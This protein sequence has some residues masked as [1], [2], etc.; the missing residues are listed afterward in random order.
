MPSSRPAATAASS[1]TGAASPGPWPSATRG[2]PA[3]VVAVLP[4]VDVS[5]S[6]SGDYERFFEHDGVR[7]HHLIDPRSGRSP[8]S[9][10][11]VTILADDGLM[12]RG[13][14]PSAC[15]CSV[16]DDG[17]RLIEAQAG[18][19]AVVVDAAGALHFSSGLRGPDGD[20]ACQ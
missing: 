8:D 3:E 9:V 19:D 13:A 18:V 6:T 17:L 12:Q 10:H 20:G 1:A 11:S 2:A 4:L 14:C 5:I 16:C 15:S 7:C